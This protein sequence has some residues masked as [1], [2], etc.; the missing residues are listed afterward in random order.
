M[1]K[2]LQVIKNRYFSLAFSALLLVIGIVC[3]CLFG[4]NKGI[5]F[6][7]GLSERIQIAPVGFTATYTG[8]KD[9]TL[10]VSRNTLVLTVRSSEGVETKT[11]DSI[12]YPT[13]NDL[14][15]ELNKTEGVN[16]KVVNGELPVKLLVSGFGFPAAL[17][18]EVTK[19]NFASS[20]KDV[21]I[22]DIREALKGRNVNVQ[23]VGAVSDGIFSLKVNT[24]EGDTQEKMEKDIAAMLSQ[25]F[26]AENV[27]VLQSDFVGPR[28]SS[29]LITTSVKA[30]AI[31]VLLILAYI[32]IRFR[33]AYALSSVLALVHDVLMMLSFIVVFKLEVSSITIAAVL[34]IIGYSLNNTIVIFDRVR[35]NV[36]LYK[37]MKIDKIIDMSVTQSMTRTIITSLTTLFAVVPLSIFSTGSIQLFALNLVWG[38]VIGTYSSNFLAPVLLHWLNKVKPIDIEKPKNVNFESEKEF[39]E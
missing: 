8:D 5:D 6:E 4:F 27:V 37:G 17:N 35:E 34:T 13:V 38:V 21:S 36:K 16:A 11:F 31:A 3:F 39:V 15:K 1:K 22:E 12:T 10:S 18:E 26:G 33:F 24:E 9:L 29:T 32:W 28:F 7:S 23:T 14:V 2:K 19:V 25:S 30:I 20:T